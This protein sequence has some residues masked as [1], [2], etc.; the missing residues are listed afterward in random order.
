MNTKSFIHLIKVAGKGLSL[1]LGI[2]ALLFSLLF[3]YMSLK[4]G[5]ELNITLLLP[6]FSGVFLIFV[7]SKPIEHTVE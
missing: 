1:V 3:F 7:G 4:N 2:R 6:M 5:Q